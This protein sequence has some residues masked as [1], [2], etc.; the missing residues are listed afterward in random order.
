MIPKFSSN[1]DVKIEQYRTPTYR[2]DF[3]N[4]RIVGKVSGNDAMVQA[5]RKILMTERYSER[6][7]SG[8][9]GVEFSRLVGASIPFVES[10]LQMTLD[11]AFSSDSR[12][13][14][15]RDIQ[16]SR[17]NC[18]SIVSTCRVLTDSGD[19]SAEFIIGG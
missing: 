9:Y 11:E 7:Y 13:R 19:V 15:V 5:V 10:N 12:I 17:I 2:I 6:I 3:E 1:L 14:G 16:I 4:K 8:D 18:D